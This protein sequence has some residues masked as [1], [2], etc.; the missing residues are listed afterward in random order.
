MGKSKWADYSD[1]NRR[2][3]QFPAEHTDGATIAIAESA[4]RYQLRPFYVES[5]KIR[6]FLIFFSSLHH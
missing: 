6:R 4:A 3:S 2:D 5:E 1:V